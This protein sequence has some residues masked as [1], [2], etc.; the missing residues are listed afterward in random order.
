MEQA[1]GWL[2]G[3][4]KT[5]SRSTI[6]GHSYAFGALALRLVAFVIS[7]LSLI[8]GWKA[9]LGRSVVFVR[10]QPRGTVPGSDRVSSVMWPLGSGHA[11]CAPAW[12]K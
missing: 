10:V 3:Y 6:R 8:F 7:R 2:C 9:A 12:D 11:S 4:D 5:L 1:G